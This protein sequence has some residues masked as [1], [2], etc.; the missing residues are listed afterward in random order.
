MS[1]IFPCSDSVENDQRRLLREFLFRVHSEKAF[2]KSSSF[3]S[4]AFEAHGIF[5]ITEELNETRLKRH[6]E[7]G[8]KIRPPSSFISFFDSL[9]AAEVRAR[10]QYHNAPPA[11]LATDVSVTRIKTSGMRK[12]EYHPADSDEVIPLWVDTTNLDEDTMSMSIESLQKIP[13]TVWISIAEVRLVF[14][15]P[16]WKGQDDEW[17]ACGHILKAKVDRVMHYDGDNGEWNLV[18]PHWNSIGEAD[19]FA[20]VEVEA[21][22]KE[23]SIP[24]IFEED[25]EEAHSKEGKISII[26]KEDE[27]EAHSKE[28]E[29]SVI[30]EEDVK[31]DETSCTIVEDEEEAQSLTGGIPV[32]SEEDEEGVQR[33]EVNSTTSQVTEVADEIQKL[34]LALEESVAV[35]DDWSKSCTEHTIAF[36]AA[37]RKASR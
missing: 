37:V 18:T 5:D 33:K 34:R 3:G 36:M 4:F 6:L 23:D 2:T 31:E 17:L 20:N 29:I 15:I 19:A 28:V 32:T 14:D 27:E 9:G 30:Y 7:W 1:I 24:V 16:H 21:H 11:Y 22:S 12:A 26:F 25:E 13:V 8:D 10:F 35:L